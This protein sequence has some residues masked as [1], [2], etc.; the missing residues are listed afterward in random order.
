MEKDI[1]I[2]VLDREGELINLQIPT[3]MGLNL[4]EAC[5]AYELPVEGICGGM[6]LCASCHVYVESNHVSLD[7]NNEEQAMLDEIDDVKE[8]SRLGCQIPI[9]PQLDG[10]LVHLAPV[11]EE[12]NF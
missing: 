8:N 6:A 2:K 1:T 4:M 3:D 12:I 5:K 10:L 11:N 7:R 9:T